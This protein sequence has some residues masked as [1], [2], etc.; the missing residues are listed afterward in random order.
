M[1]L[2]PKH[3]LYMQ[4]AIVVLVVASIAIAAVKLA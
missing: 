2:V 1:P 4:Y 3:W